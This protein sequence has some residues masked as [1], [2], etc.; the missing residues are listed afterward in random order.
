VLKAFRWRSWLVIA[1]LLSVSSLAHAYTRAYILN[2]TGQQ[3]YSLHV[4]LTQAALADSAGTGQLIPF[5]KKAVVSADGLTLDFSVP[6]FPGILP[7]ELVWLGWTDAD[8]SLSGQIASYWWGDANGNPIGGVQ[9]PSGGNTGL[10]SF[11]LGTSNIGVPTG[12][13]LAG[14]DTGTQGAAGSPGATGPQGAAGSP[15]ATGPQGPAGTQGPA[16]PQGATGPQGTTSQITIPVD[17]DDA[18][19]HELPGGQTTNPDP[20][21]TVLQATPEPGT[22]ALLAGG[23]LAIGWS[24]R[25]RRYSRS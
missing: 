4:K 13:G 15:G 12:A 2:N 6:L 8:P 3:A 7:G 24:V 18:D 10:L 19:G 20:G 25:R 14:A 1:A 9:Y 22:I 21:G 23:L 17:D 16:G 5:F 11:G